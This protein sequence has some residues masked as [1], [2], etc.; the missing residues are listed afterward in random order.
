M[1]NPKPNAL[2]TFIVLFCTQAENKQAQPQG[3]VFHAQGS[4]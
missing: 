4:K 2:L 1:R 3:K